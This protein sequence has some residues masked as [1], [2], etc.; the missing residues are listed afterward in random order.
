MSLGCPSKGYQAVLT[1]VQF[2]Q[3]GGKRRGGHS[4]T[5]SPKTKYDAG[6]DDCTNECPNKYFEPS[7]AFDQVAKKL[8][9]NAAER[10]TDY[11]RDL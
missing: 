8:A 7:A 4:R 2:Y 10:S 9:S 5:N 3:G 1:R 6:D 11:S